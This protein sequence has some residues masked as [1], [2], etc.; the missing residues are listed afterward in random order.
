MALTA[1]QFEIL[2][3][4]SDLRII[5]RD[6]INLDSMVYNLA[7]LVY[8]SA[9]TVLAEIADASSVSVPAVLPLSRT[10]ETLCEIFCHDYLCNTKG[11]TRPPL[12]KFKL[13]FIITMKGVQ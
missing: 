12:C 9:H 10:I 1:K 4:E 11:G 2:P 8:P 5:D 6:R 3:I 7:R 13:L